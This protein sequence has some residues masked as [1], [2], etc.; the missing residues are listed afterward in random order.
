M[1]D[2]LLEDFS[3]N[4][5]FL[6]FSETI[7]EIEG[8]YRGAKEEPDPFSKTEGKRIVYSIQGKD[9]VTRVLNSVSKRLAKAFVEAGVTIGDQ[10][11]IMRFGSGYDTN[12]GVTIIAKKATTA[13][14]EEAPTADEVPF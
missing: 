4:D 5:N 10:I 6:K 9:Q 11:R 12:Y 13:T 14:Q 1:S 2:S 3:K 7:K 8:T